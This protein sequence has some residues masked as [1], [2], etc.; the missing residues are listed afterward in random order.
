MVQNQLNRIEAKLDEIKNSN[1][2]WIIISVSTA[3][4]VSMLFNKENLIFFTRKLEIN[5]ITYLLDFIITLL[6][7]TTI[8]YSLIIGTINLFNYIVKKK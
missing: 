7:I 6:L 3:T 2:K 1:A 5:Q 4:M 8:T